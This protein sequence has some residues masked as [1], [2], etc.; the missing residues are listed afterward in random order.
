LRAAE[1][2]RLA[3]DLKQPL[4]PVDEQHDLLAREARVRRAGQSS[5]R[6]RASAWQF[7]GVLTIAGLTSMKPEIGFAVL[8][9]K[10]SRA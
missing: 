1:V 7:V 4:G 3:D 2:A 8:P 5:G 6:S 10:V 9:S